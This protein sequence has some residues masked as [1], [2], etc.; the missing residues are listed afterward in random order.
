MKGIIKA[1]DKKEFYIEENCF[2]TELI[3]ASDTPKCS[4]SKA[5]VEVGAATQPH[6]LR[7]TDELY[8]ILAGRGEMEIDGFITGTA[9]QGDLVFI[10]QNARQCIRNTGNEDLVFLCI[11]TPRFEMG[12]YQAL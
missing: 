6:A 4:V 8:Y 7:D 10:P 9:E 5:R 12:N 2:I 11:C 1:A 3:N